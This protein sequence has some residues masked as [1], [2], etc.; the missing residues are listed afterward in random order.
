M[1]INV[2]PTFQLGGDVPDFNVLAGPYMG[3]DF[4]DIFERH[5]NRLFRSGQTAG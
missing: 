1:G 3:D 4:D 2:I 5:R